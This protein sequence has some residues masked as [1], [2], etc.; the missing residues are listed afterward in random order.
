MIKN[1]Y[2]LLLLLC[3][4]LTLSSCS[5]H[6]KDDSLTVQI[7]ENDTLFVCDLSKVNNKKEVCLSD[8]IEEFM[9]VRFEN[10]DTALIKAWKVY[11]TDHYIGILQSALSPFKLF[12]HTGKFI[13]DIGGIGQGVGEYTMLY[14]GAIDEKHAAVWLAPF[15]GTSLWK[16]NLKG[17]HIC[18]VQTYKMNK[19]QI[20]CEPDGSLTLTHLCFAGI[21]EF[22]YLNLFNPDSLYYVKP[23]KYQA[24]QPRDNKGNYVGFNHEVWSYNNSSD[25]SYMTTSS[26]TLYSYNRLTMRTTPRFTTLHHP[27]DYCIY[28]ELPSCFLVNIILSNTSLA[29]HKSNM[30]VVGKNR[31]HSY[32]VEIVNDFLGHLPVSGVVNFSNG[33]YYEMFEPYQLIELIQKHLSFK[34]GSDK[35]V[36]EKMLHSI[37]EDGN[38]ILFMGKLKQNL[39]L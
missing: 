33:W 23:I 13:C 14:S 31:M 27:N 6:K 18:T 37:N 39:S 22:Q 30:I 24:V 26:D 12:D 11:I 10:T 21:S 29:K 5:H 2:I 38:N 4:E 19:P 32:Y 20:R 36:L 25:F 8:W 28:N 1:A 35:E 34:D 15:T 3:S 17:K 7:E 9:V 16:Y